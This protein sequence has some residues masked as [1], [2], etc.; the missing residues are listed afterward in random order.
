ML[1]VTALAEA[2][3]LGLDLVEVNAMTSATTRRNLNERMINARRRAPTSLVLR[4]E[5]CAR[6]HRRSRAERHPHEEPPG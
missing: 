3:R 4:D 1:G 6:A 2:L 5:S